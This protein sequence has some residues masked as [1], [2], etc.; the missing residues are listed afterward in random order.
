MILFKQLLVRLNQVVRPNMG[1]ALF[2]LFLT[3]ICET[4]LGM[5]CAAPAMIRLSRGVNSLNDL[6]FSG[7]LLFCTLIVWLLFQYGFHILILRM[8]RHEYVTLGYVFYG[9]KKIKKTLPLMLTISVIVAVLTVAFVA[10]GRIV[11]AKSGLAEKVQETIVTT[12]AEEQTQDTT[13]SG[14]SPA[15]VADAEQ[16][17]DFNALAEKHGDVMN[18]VLKQTGIM[19]VIY[20]LLIAAV[21]IRFAFVFYLHFD[22]PA[23]SVFT[24]FRKSA[25]MMKKNVLR[26][27]H[28]IL[29]A[30]GRNL[31]FAA[32]AFG[33]TLLIPTAN[34]N[35][36]KG[37]FPI[38]A[39]ILN[40]AY[41]VNAY[42]ALLRMY[43]AFPVLYDSLQNP[44]SYNSDENTA[45]MLKAVV[46]LLAENEKDDSTDSEE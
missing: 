35:G 43:F 14:D 46:S 45:A 13:E 34:A 32:A 39:L 37:G 11:M 25:R 30:S 18:S 4:V 6:I 1:N 36:T 8:T 15:L 40:L 31:A 10:A 2:A 27:I 12:Q 9:L 33:M 20:F 22:N 3:L 38:L 26:L 42:T 44:S 19:L 24:L 7:L 17:L 21:F 28:L 23:D 16:S 5:I 29:C 41:L